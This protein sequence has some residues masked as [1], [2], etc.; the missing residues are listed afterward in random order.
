M[1]SRSLRFLALTCSIPLCV[2]A[3]SPEQSA[4]QSEESNSDMQTESSPSKSEQSLVLAEVNGTA[5][6]QLDL[7]LMVEKLMGENAKSVISA[8]AKDRV[9]QSL[10]ASEAMRI[11]LAK[12]LSADEIKTLQAKARAYETE[13]YV[14]E[15]LTRY[16]KPETVT[17]S[18]VKEYYQ[19]NLDQFR[20][21]AIT[22]YEMLVSGTVMEAEALDEF[23]KDLAA[24]PSSASLKSL[25]NKSYAGNS[26]RFVVAESKENLLSN[27]QAA[28]LAATSVGSIT[29]PVVTTTQTA[30]FKILAR[31]KQAP[32]P[33]DQVGDDIRRKLAPMQVK[34]AVKLATDNALSDAN[35]IYRTQ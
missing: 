4:T 11:K 32:A 14:K 15:F 2:V 17:S 8:S 31:E 6:T 12:E 34:K 19:A 16:S 27:K 26:L 13:L 25:S 20:P 23:K 9:L 21:P 1:I 10:A 3:C 30:A 5:I 29:T 28:V 18:M 22:Q 33:L 7:D 35:V 24:L